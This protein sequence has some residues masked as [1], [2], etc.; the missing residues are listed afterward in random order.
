MIFSGVVEHAI[1]DLLPAS[2]EQQQVQYNNLLSYS[3]GFSLKYNNNI[4]F[5]GSYSNLG[6]SGKKEISVQSNHY[7]I[8]D[9]EFYDLGL[10]NYSS[11]IIDKN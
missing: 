1:N 2:S 9:S 10:K 8:I 3:A 5:I 4:A 7:K 6:N 11:R